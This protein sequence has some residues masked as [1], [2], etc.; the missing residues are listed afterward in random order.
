[1]RSLQLLVISIL[2]YMLAASQSACNNYGL[3]DKLESPGKAQ[4]GSGFSLVNTIF[5]TQA[6]F[7]GNLGGVAVL[8]A[9]VA[10]MRQ[11][12]WGRAMASGKL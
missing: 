3:V 1:M 8:T 9:S 7:N 5:V 11:T 10:T 12:P 2:V 4:G 6:T